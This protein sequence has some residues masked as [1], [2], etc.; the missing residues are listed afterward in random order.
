MINSYFSFT[1][2]ET[3]RIVSFIHEYL[4]IYLDSTVGHPVLTIKLLLML[5][6][7]I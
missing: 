2:S 3:F 5:M 4:N 1:K 7:Q 6:M